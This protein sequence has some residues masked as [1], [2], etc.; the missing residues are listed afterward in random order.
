M[1]KRWNKCVQ[2]GLKLIYIL[3]IIQNCLSKTIANSFIPKL[4]IKKKHLLIITFHPAIPLIPPILLNSI[5]N[6][7]QSKSKIKRNKCPNKKAEQGRWFM[8]NHKIVNTLHLSPQLVNNR[9][10]RWE[11][12]LSLLWRKAL[13]ADHSLAKKEFLYAQNQWVNL[14]LWAKRKQIMTHQIT[15]KIVKVMSLKREKPIAEVALKNM[16][17][18]SDRQPNRI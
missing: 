9:F 3:V 16:I 18:Q 5:V 4:Q 2:A 7:K 14:F 1:R 11:N 10:G 6:R 8:T 13:K 12:K 15:T 17:K